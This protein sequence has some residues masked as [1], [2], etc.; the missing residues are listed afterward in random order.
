MNK[1]EQKSFIKV[2]VALNNTLTDI[3]IHNDLVTVYGNFFYSY[4]AIANWQVHL[5]LD[6]KGVLSFRTQYQMIKTE[7]YLYFLLG[8]KFQNYFIF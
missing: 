1:R 2:S 4:K 3:H 7:F 8:T 6:E 5:S